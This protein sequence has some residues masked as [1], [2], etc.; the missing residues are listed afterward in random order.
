MN[1]KTKQQLNDYESEI[2]KA[3]HVSLGNR[4]I[5][6]HITMTQLGLCAERIC[7][8]IYIRRYKKKSSLTFFQ[9]INDFY[10]NDIIDIQIKTYLV[11]ARKL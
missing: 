10:N 5:S 7:Q 2:L 3:W 8:A 11:S 9:M 1:V 4:K 6:F